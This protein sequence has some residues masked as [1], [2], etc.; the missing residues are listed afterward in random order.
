MLSLVENKEGGS[1]GGGRAQG[2][3]EGP[4]IEQQPSRVRDRLAEVLDAVD[5]GRPTESVNGTLGSAIEMLEAILNRIKNG[6]ATGLSEVTIV[7]VETTMPETVET[8]ELAV[9]ADVA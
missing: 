3:P 8:V 6:A 1:S 7:E 4:T 9:E 5:A 2:R